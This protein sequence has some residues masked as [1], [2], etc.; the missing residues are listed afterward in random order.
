MSQARIYR[1]KKTQKVWVCNSCQETIP[2]GSACISFAVGFRGYE[3]RRCTKPECQPTR[4]QLESSMTAE[5]YEAIDGA[6]PEMATS[7][8]DLESIR[9]EVCEAIASVVS[10]YQEN[11]MYENNYDLQERAEQL[12]GSQSELESW[13]FDE[14][15]PEEEPEC[16]ECEG[17][18]S[19][20]KDD[21]AWDN[22]VITVDCEQ[23]SG[24]GKLDRDEE[25][26]VEWLETAKASL[27]EALD[28]VEI[29]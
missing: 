5:I 18:G 11:P 6:N 10:Q 29:P 21:P 1:T 27:Q 25:A 15:E 20:D 17:T 16:E 4:A 28:A 8:E 3:Q 9:D 13:S 2:K 24:T 22:L 26:H 19:I 14:E 23:C 12:E 7:L